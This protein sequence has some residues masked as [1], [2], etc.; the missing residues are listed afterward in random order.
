MPCHVC[1]VSCPTAL[2]KFVPENLHNCQKIGTIP[3][4]SKAFRLLCEFKKKRDDQVADVIECAK[5]MIRVLFTKEDWKGHNFGGQSG[6]HPLCQVKLMNVVA[7]L[8]KRFPEPMS[9][10]TSRRVKWAPQFLVTALNKTFRKSRSNETRG[11]SFSVT[12]C[13]LVSVLFCVFSNCVFDFI[14][15]W[16]TV[17][18]E[19]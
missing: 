15:L 14:C 17:F 18:C 12:A 5:R 1:N 4:N 19:W 11:R 7:E 10:G 8:K 16:L 3:I 2:P 13:M 9:V 6:M